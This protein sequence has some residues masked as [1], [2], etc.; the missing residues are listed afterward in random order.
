MS[1]LLLSGGIESATLLHERCGS[2]DLRALFI[3]YGQRAARAERAA[4]T[5]LCARTGTP[6]TAVSLKGL[7]A[8]APAAVWKPHVPLAA[9][10]LLAVSLAANHALALRARGVLL[11]LQRDDQGHREGAPP[12]IAAL[13]DTLAALGLEL[14]VPYR[15]LSKVAVVARGRALGVDYTVTYS[16]L[17]GRRTPCGRCPQCRSRAHALAC[18]S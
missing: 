11:G 16:C 18:D 12:F 15:K 1:I 3:D 17:L 13:A 10:N 14:E 4:A 9:R 2:S 7:G 5:A 6:L 8:L